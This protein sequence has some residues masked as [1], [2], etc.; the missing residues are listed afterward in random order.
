MKNTL[1]PS[2]VSGPTRQPRQCRDGTARCRLRWI[3]CTAF[4][5]LT[6]LGARPAGAVPN[7]LINGSFEEPVVSGPFITRSGGEID[8]WTITSGTVDQIGT[9]WPAALG[10]QSIDL[11]GD[12]PGRIEQTFDTVAGRQYHF[13]GYYAN[14]PDNPAGASTADVFL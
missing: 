8:G 1:T 14:N 6:C 12:G 3:A 13:S 11:A 10:A 9:Y 2:G 4:I 7:R 5:L